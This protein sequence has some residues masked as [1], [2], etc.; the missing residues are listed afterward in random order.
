M[1]FKFKDTLPSGVQSLSFSN[2]DDIKAGQ[3]I[4]AVS[5]ADRDVVSIGI[6]SSLLN[7]N[8]EQKKLIEIDTTISQDSL[9]SGTPF[10]NLDGNVVAL[11]IGKDSNGND[12]LMPI[13]RVIE[14]IASLAVTQ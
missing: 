10:L 3:S 2:D 9:L 5:G 8:T 13:S 7:D 11:K 6:V 4:I 12:I 1:T 14:G